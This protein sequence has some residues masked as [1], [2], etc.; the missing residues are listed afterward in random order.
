MKLPVVVYPDKKLKLISKPVENFNT[1][2]H[3]FLDDMYDTMI[4]SNGIGL[5]AIQVAKPIRALLLCMPDDE[6][7]Q[8]KEVLLEII[9]PKV[10]NEEGTIVYQEGCLSVPSFYE[11]IERHEKLTLDYQD[12]HGKQMRIEAEG[13][14]SVA[15]QHE[16]DHLDGKL[17]IE[18]LPYGRRKKFDKEY[19]KLQKAKKNPSE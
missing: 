5:A 13:L 16:I 12:R 2:L 19:R 6:G 14:L 1:D 17:F 18:K 4:Q 10:S 11:D 3:S 7:E 9:N 8:S 15:I